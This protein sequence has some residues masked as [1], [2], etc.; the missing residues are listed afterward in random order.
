[1]NSNAG[2]TFNNATAYEAYVGRWSNLWIKQK[3]SL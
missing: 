1:M 3:D 2:D